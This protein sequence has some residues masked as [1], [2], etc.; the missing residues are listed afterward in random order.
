MPV[1][2]QSSDHANH[3]IVSQSGQDSSGTSRGS[4]VDVHRVVQE[5][6]SN[7]G[8]NHEGKL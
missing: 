6:Q 8:V 5:P 7:R 3:Q 2:T 1:A 4:F